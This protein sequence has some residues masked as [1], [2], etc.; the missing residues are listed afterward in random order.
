MERALANW[1]SQIL[2][3]AARSDWSQLKRRRPRLI[4]LILLCD[5][6]N[7]FIFILEITNKFDR[8]VTWLCCWTRQIYHDL[9]RAISWQVIYCLDAFVFFTRHCADGAYSTTVRIYAY[10]IH[11][12]ATLTTKAIILAEADGINFVAKEMCSFIALNRALIH[13]FGAK[14]LSLLEAC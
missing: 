2:H 14:V 6:L 12:I 11:L 9:S 7:V 5:W 8:V 1:H 3:T 4:T 13:F 10:T